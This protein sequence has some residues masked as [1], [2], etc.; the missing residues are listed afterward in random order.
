MSPGSPER[1]SKRRQACLHKRNRLA[2]R[3]RQPAYSG[4]LR[5]RK[6]LVS[7]SAYCLVAVVFGLVVPECPLAGLAVAVIA[8]A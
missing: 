1:R 4:M 6:E 7:P 3:R 8:A 5:D 2:P